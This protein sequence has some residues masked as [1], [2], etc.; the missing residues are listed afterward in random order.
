MKTTYCLT[1]ALLAWLVT[2]NSL[3]GQMIFTNIIRGVGANASGECE[4]DFDGVDSLA[5]GIFSASVSATALDTVSPTCQSTAI[6]DASQMSE[7]SAT[8]IIGSGETNGES[9]ANGSST[10]M[11]GIDV[12]F[13][14]TSPTAYSLTGTLDGFLSTALYPDAPTFG[15]VEL[16][17]INSGPILQV[18]QTTGFV[19]ET[20]DFNGTLD[21]GDYY[22]KVTA[23]TFT[24]AD[25]ASNSQFDIM[26][27]VPEPSIP[28]FALFLVLIVTHRMRSN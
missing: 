17:D 24:N 19:P 28:V 18:S 12:E 8:S 16:V 7:I 4:T 26:F 22:L 20:F 27:T 21:A 15:I 23:T 3:C 2:A 5:D 6:S 25:A 9:T 1:L 14:L 13:T 11:S 10:G